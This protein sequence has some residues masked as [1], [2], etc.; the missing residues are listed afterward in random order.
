[1]KQSAASQSHL[2]VGDWSTHRRSTT[3]HLKKRKKH[4][5]T[6]ANKTCMQIVSTSQ[7][8][9]RVN[10]E[11]DQHVAILTAHVVLVVTSCLV[12]NE[13]G[14]NAGQVTGQYTG[15]SVIQRRQSNYMHTVTAWQSMDNGKQT[16]TGG[17]VQLFAHSPATSHANCFLL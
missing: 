14:E 7:T 12:Q 6:T 8:S 11:T 15:W 9:S 2:P 17:L 13:R 5:A 3:I 1:M 16:P 10:A 4:N